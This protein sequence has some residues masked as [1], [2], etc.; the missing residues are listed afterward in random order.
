M[1][2]IEIFFAGLREEMNDAEIAAGLTN[3]DIEKPEWM[4]IS[5]NTD[6]LKVW[7]AENG[8]SSQMG[9]VWISYDD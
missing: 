2:R 5:E 8:G 1:E 7:D 6:H 4:C 9:F 3:G